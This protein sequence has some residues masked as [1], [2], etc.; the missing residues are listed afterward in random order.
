MRIHKQSPLTYTL[1]TGA[2]LSGGCSYQP[3]QVPDDYSTSSKLT[4]PLA[5]ITQWQERVFASPTQYSLS[6]TDQQNTIT[7]V[8]DNSASMIYQEFTVDL[9][10]TPYL[11]WQWKISN[12]YTGIN[13]K[14]REGDDF[15]ARVYI[16]IKPAPLSFYPRA[17]NYVWANHS[18]TLSSWPSP[19]TSQ[20]IM[21]AVESGADKKE[22]WI[23]EVRNI[24]EDIQ[25]FFGEDISQIEGIAIMTDS[26]N[27]QSSTTAFYRNIYFSQ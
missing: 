9:N 19:Y 16:A 18:E 14:T 10:K 22:Q 7:A 11:H 17:L 24:K 25:R 23:S 15:P 1:L 6:K 13:E 20:S 27:S 8:S 4:V 2:I 12:T 26:D 3:Q 21:I 5:P